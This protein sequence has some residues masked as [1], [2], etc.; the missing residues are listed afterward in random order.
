[1]KNC[2]CLDYNGKLIHIYGFERDR[3]SIKK[4]FGR[5]SALAVFT[6]ENNFAVR[7]LKEKDGCTRN[8]G[9]RTILAL[10]MASVQNFRKAFLTPKDSKSE[11]VSRNTTKDLPALVAD[12]TF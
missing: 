11:M 10:P 6:N 3:I 1:M 9:I 2:V 7:H 12:T 4:H 5:V 8:E